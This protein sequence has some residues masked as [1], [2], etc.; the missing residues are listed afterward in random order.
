MQTWGPQL[1]TWA[2]DGGAG[3]FEHLVSREQVLLLIS[4]RAGDTLPERADTIYVGRG[5]RARFVRAQL[6]SAAPATDTS[7]QGEIWFFRA[8]ARYG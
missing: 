8:D 3:A 4:L 1:T 2:L 6:V 7:F 5:D